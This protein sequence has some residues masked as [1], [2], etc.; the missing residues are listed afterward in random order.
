[1]LLNEMTQEN[2]T[3]M[4]NDVTEL[5]TDKLEAIRVASE[6]DFDDLSE[7]ELTLLLEIFGIENEQSVPK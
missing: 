4:H 3:N 2:I 5:F 7:M 1:M 6:Y